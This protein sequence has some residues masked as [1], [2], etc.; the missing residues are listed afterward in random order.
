MGEV[1]HRNE[2]KN[3]TEAYSVTAHFVEAFVDVVRSAT[4]FLQHRRIMIGQGL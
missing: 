1:L 4:R 3:G 2:T